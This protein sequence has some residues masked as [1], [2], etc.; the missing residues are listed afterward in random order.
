MATDAPPDADAL[1]G[2]VDEL[3]G[4][5]TAEFT[6]A[7]NA[8]AKELRGTDRA[9]A[10][11]VKDLPRPS[12]AAWA[13]NLLAR[14]HGEELEQL[15]GLGAQLREAQ[16]QLDG[17]ELRE[18]NKQQHLVLAGI[19]RQAEAAAAGA[20]QPLSE[21]VARQ[22]VATV[23]AGMAEPEAAD[24]VRS[25]QLVRDLES[26]GFG[27]VDLEG[28]LGAPELLGRAPTRRGPARR[29]PASSASR[30]KGGATS[31]GDVGAAS[32]SGGKATAGPSAEE[33]AAAKA[34]AAE[35]ERRRRRAEAE[36]V[37]AEA[38]EAAE[39]ARAAVDRA[40]AEADELSTRRADFEATVAELTARLAEAERDVDDVTRRER[41]AREE[42][43][44]A[45]RGAEA[46][47]RRVT[48]AEAA[49]DRLPT[50]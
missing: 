18:L 37:L 2:V 17:A 44:R 19:R 31:S 45:R 4:L 34:R 28:A 3:Y 36:R 47:D 30:A 41:R 39:E 12:T 48:Q 43:D 15:L 21:S 25:G 11:R 24:V 10:D 13:V 23:R 35:E 50:P 1:A 6:A 40:Q 14:E 5:P 42:R 29:E 46:A 22:V 26:T 20:G 33:A 7:R 8:R 49:L 32:S 38:R 27:A 9:L 16:E